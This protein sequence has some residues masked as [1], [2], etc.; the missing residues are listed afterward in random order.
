MP[1]FIKKLIKYWPYGAGAAVFA[2][3]FSFIFHHTANHLS[4]QKMNPN[5]SDMIVIPEPLELQGARMATPDEKPV[6]VENSDDNSNPKDY[7]FDNWVFRFK[8]RPFTTPQVAVVLTGIGLY[9]SNKL[10]ELIPFQTTL[11][12]SPYAHAYPSGLNLYEVWLDAPLESITMNGNNLGPQVIL[13]DDPVSIKQYAAKMNEFSNIKGI[14]AE[15][16][17]RFTSSYKDMDSFLSTLHFKG[18]MYLDSK[19]ALA[20]PWRRVCNSL[21]MP[22]LETDFTFFRDQNTQE[23]HNILDMAEKMALQTG[24]VV[25]KIPFYPPLIPQVANWIQSLKIKKIELV[26]LSSLMH[27]VGRGDS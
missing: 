10:L 8:K 19:R 24:W 14:V 13:T 11:S 15:E 18:H 9:G 12:I 4:K 25:I 7:L 5:K 27:K 1:E 3:I 16:G 26:P 20:S 23:L 17:S 6:V 22:C 2:L 21:N